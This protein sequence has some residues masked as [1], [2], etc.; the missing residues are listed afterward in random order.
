G[1]ALSEE[2]GKRFQQEILAVGG[3]RPARE[4]FQAVRGREPS[5]DAMLR[6]SGMSS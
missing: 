2:T 1:G 3:A 5:N 6:H 4:S